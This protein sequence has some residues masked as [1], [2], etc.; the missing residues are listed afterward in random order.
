MA[1]GPSNASAAGAGVSDIFAG[2][3]DE[4]K[5]GIAK[6]EAGEYT[7]A[8]NLAEQN[9]QITAGSTA[10]KQAQEARGISMAMGRTEA[11]EAGAGF[12][13]KGSALYLLRMNAQQGSITQ[14]VA[15]RQGLV[16][17][18]AYTEQAESYSMMAS[19]ANSAASADKTAAIGSFIAGG[20]N[21]VA[22]AIPTPAPAP[23]S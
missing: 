10:I 11:G 6:E 2:F 9:A 1:Y 14:S 17:Q 23:S 20:I 5:A 16:Q 12:A 13:E 18:A 15:E 19:A 8:E 22:A 21:L 3:G 4:A 7:L